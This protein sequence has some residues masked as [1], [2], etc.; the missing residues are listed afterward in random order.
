MLATVHMVVPIL[1]PCIRPPLS[2]LRPQPASRGE[3]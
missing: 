3:E 1:Q 2:P